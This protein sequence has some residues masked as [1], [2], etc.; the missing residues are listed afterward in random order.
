[1]EVSISI[2]LPEFDGVTHGVPV[3][4]KKVLDNGDIRYIPIPERIAHMIS[5]AKNGPC[6]AIN[7][8]PI[9]K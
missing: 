1:M 7:Q 3:A 2:S 9:K 5:K 4:T 6:C 8:M